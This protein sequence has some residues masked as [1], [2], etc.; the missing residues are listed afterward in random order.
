MSKQDKKLEAYVLG[1]GDTMDKINEA[2][3]QC[4]GGLT[5]IIYKKNEQKNL[6]E[7]KLTLVVC[8]KKTYTNLCN[9]PS[10]GSRIQPYDWSHFRLPN[11]EQEET[12]SIHVS[13]LPQTWTLDQAEKFLHERVCKVIP[14]KLVDSTTRQTVPSWTI[15]LK[16]ENR[17]TG[18]ILGFGKIEFHDDVGDEEIQI[19]KLLLHNMAVPVERG[20]KAKN[21]HFLMAIWHTRTQNRQ[22][23]AFN[24]REAT[25]GGPV[26]SAVQQLKN[27]QR[28][29]MKRGEVPQATSTT[30]A[31]GSAEPQTPSSLP[32][33]TGGPQLTNQ[34]VVAPPIFVQIPPVAVPAMSI[35]SFGVK[36]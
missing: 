2:V 31:A 20:E 32:N 22:K 8:T 16:L 19:V 35:P 24:P 36:V 13:G 28:R 14:A 27:N 23:K 34:P 25:P 30:S 3:T 33:L 6:V 12:W 10:Y 9:H 18:R 26:G 17:E 21:R 11:E 1:S 7:T 15:N 5:K 4:G 29:V